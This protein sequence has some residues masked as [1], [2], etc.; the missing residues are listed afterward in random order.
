MA[1]ILAIL[2]DWLKLKAMDSRLRG[3]GNVD[4]RVSL[5]PLQT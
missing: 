1:E 3:N 5:E 2:A 4:N